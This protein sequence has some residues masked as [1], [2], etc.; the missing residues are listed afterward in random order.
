MLI[1]N[2][3]FL[4]FVNEEL[5]LYGLLVYVRINVLIIESTENIRPAT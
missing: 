3:T 2:E 4:F 5:I 1:D